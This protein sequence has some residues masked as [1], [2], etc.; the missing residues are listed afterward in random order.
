MRVIKKILMLQIIEQNIIYNR[1]L[2][3]NEKKKIIIHTIENCPIILKSV[4]VKYI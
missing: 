2:I 1:E 3:C 4:I